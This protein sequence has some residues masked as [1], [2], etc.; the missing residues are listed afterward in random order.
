MFPCTSCMNARAFRG[1][2][3]RGSGSFFY[4][5]PVKLACCLDVALPHLRDLLFSEDKC[6]VT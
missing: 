5:A 1:G 6:L 4:G 3:G 2:Y